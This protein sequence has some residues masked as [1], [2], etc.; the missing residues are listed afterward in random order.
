[1]QLGF[2]TLYLVSYFLVIKLSFYFFFSCIHFYNFL[3]N[4]KL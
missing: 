3:F 2:Y 4:I 1:L